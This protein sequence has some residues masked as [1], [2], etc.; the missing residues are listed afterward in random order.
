MHKLRTKIFWTIF[1]ILSLFIIGITASFNIQEY[2]S[3]H[4]RV[5]ENLNFA[6]RAENQPG[7]NRELPKSDKLPPTKNDNRQF[8]DR[9]TKFI[10]A[11]VYTVLIESDEVAEIINHS[12]NDSS[13]DEVSY[14]ATQILSHPNP[15]AR[16]IGCLYFEKYSY[17]YLKDSALIIVDN[18]NL[19]QNLLQTLFLS[20]CIVILLEIISY[21]VTKLITAWLITP[22]ETSFEKQ[23]QFIADASH[24]LKTPLSVI[25]ASSDLLKNDPSNQKWLSSIIDETGRMNSLVT[26]LL[27]L[28]TSEVATED[29]MEVK[30]LSKVIKLTTLAFEGKA[31]EKH[32]KLKSSIEDNVQLL[33]QEDAIKQLIEILLDNAIEHSSPRK[34]IQVSLAN[35]NKSILL[36]VEN[37]GKDI[38]AGEEELIFERFYRV[39]KSRNRKE[40]RYGLGLAIAKNIVEHHN[41]KISA[42][43]H[44]GTTTFT[45]TFKK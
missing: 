2:I 40:N 22:V 36:T 16:H 20:I 39:D 28:S 14:L 4:N 1:T 31:Y 12:T 21:F 41:G 37:Q 7:D 42:T 33:I 13:D 8:L 19:R 23:K 15:P 35:K 25:I 24:E 18:S 32:L 29:K 5:V 3:S 17:L 26:K 44:D 10:D 38:P 45:V 30:N 43:S 9:N 34:T 11:T 6:S 27:E